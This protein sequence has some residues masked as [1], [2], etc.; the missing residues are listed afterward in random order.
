MF[1]SILPSHAWLWTSTYIPYAEG[2]P[3]TSFFLDHYF[4]SSIL[5][6]TLQ[7]PS[8]PTTPPPPS[9]T[10]HLSHHIS[11][12]TPHYISLHLT[13]NHFSHHTISRTH[14]L[15]PFL[16]SHHISH[17]TPHIILYLPAGQNPGQPMWNQ[18]QN[19]NPYGMPQMPSFPPSTAYSPPAVADPLTTYASLVRA[20]CRT[21]Q[22][23]IFLL[24]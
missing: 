19:Q 4:I 12:T 1:F 2:A 22:N 17:S 5:R 13:L 20:Y 18:N 3:S 14:H 11:H 8:N 23:S 6:A 10:P 7:M 24:I 21:L 15:T 9:L 16:T